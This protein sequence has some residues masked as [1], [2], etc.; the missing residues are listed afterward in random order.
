MA[1][2]PLLNAGLFAGMPTPVVVNIVATQCLVAT[3]AVNRPEAVEMCD[4]HRVFWPSH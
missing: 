1:S 3:M 4:M 2:D